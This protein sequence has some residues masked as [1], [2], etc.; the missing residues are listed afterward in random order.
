MTSLTTPRRIM[1][2]RYIMKAAKSLTLFCLTLLLAG[3]SSSPTQLDVATESYDDLVA[4]FGVWREYRVPPRV[5]GVP[6]FSRKAIARQWADFPAWRAALESFD[7]Q[8][9]PVSQ[10]VDWH[11]VRAELN[12]LQFDHEVL[13]PWERDPAYYVYFY[14]NPTDVPSREG[15]MIEGSLEVYYYDYPLS[16]GDAS[17]IEAGLRSMPALYESARANLT[18]NARDLWLKGIESIREQ[19]GALESY[20]GRVAENRPGIS[21]A[22]NAARQASDEFADWLEEQADSK[23]G[24]SGV[25]KDNITWALQNIH[26]IPLTWEEEV[27]LVKR[28]LVRA[29]TALRLEEN[30][31]RALPDLKRI[32]SPDEYDRRLNA[33][34]D[35]YMMFLEEEEI[36]PL[37]DYMDKALRDR[38]GSF[39]SLSSPDELRGFFSEVGYRDEM[40][41]R[42]HQ[43]HW[44][45]LARMRF[46]PHPSP[47]RS[48][49]LW[50]NIFDGRAEGF[51]TSMEEMMMH[52]GLFDARPRGRELVWILLA[53]RAARALGGLYQHSNEMTLEQATKFA[54]QWTPRGYL[55]WDGSTIQHEQHFYLRQPTYGESYVIGKIEIEKLLAARARQLGD[56]FTLYQFMD[57]FNGAGVIP[58][59]LINWELSGDDS[60]IRMM[61]TA[62]K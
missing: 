10:Q 27:L 6:D 46:E 35:E 52:A 18:G 54:D 14:P 37:K 25:G 15:P 22:A 32:D 49:P 48:S 7:I 36:L 62:T 56:D 39:S 57:D 17:H 41:M 4:Y 44:F 8:D 5:E 58:V 31:N 33:A 51:A 42:T 50:Y 20:S 26:Y 9:W 53:Q 2:E 3:C 16:D 1:T 47:I 55:P 34:V 43:Y 12:G 19:S 38:I 21:D 13:K 40:A 30:R 24:L 28:E 11:L 59:S 23:T 61:M 29:H 60:E 45:D